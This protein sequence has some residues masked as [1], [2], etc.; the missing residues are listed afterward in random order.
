MNVYLAQMTDRACASEI[1]LSDSPSHAAART[2]GPVLL[3]P[4]E[5]EAGEQFLQCG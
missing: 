3:L 1:V 4:V 5:F 2:H